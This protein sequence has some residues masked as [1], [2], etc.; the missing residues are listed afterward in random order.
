MSYFDLKKRALMRIINSVKGFIRTVTGTNSVTLDNC[1]DDDSLI[2]LKLY[3]NSV[4]DGTPAPDNPIEIQSVG[5]LSRN[6]F[7]KSLSINDGI[8]NETEVDT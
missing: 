2:N 5:E 4:Q 8:K 3:G 7:D 1:V 6:L